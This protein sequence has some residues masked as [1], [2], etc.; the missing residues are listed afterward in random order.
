[1]SSLRGLCETD[2][3]SRWTQSPVGKTGAL[4]TR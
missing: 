4:P 1:M 3:G 2:V